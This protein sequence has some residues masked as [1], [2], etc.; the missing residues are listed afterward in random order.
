M[1]PRHVGV[2]VLED[3]AEHGGGGVADHHRARAAAAHARREHRAE[4]RT[5]RRQMC[6]VRRDWLARRLHT[7][8]TGSLGTSTRPRL[9]LRPCIQ[10]KVNARTYAQT[11]R[12]GFI[13]SLASACYEYPRC[14]VVHFMVNADIYARK[15]GSGFNDDSVRVINTLAAWSSTCSTTN[16]TS[17]KVGSPSLHFICSMYVTCGGGGPGPCGTAGPG[18]SGAS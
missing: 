2:E 12:G 15:R 8:A 5:A 16:A 4:V 18:C 11:G 3:G 13:V 10:F 9:S 17:E 6:F 1:R 14:L 7:Q